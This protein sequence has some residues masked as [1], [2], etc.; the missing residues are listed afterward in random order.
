MTMLNRNPHGDRAHVVQPLADVESDD[1]QQRGRAQCEQ[2]ENNVERGIARKMF[3]IRLPHEEHVAGGEVEHGR[4]VGQV[5]GPISPRRHEA[6][7]I[8]EGA[9]APDIKPAFIR[10]ARR[11]FQH[12]KRQRRVET[13]PGADPDDDR[14]RPGGRGGCD[15][16]Q[17]DA[18]D[19]IKQNQVAE[20]HHL[21]GPIGIFR[22]RDGNPRRRLRQLTHCG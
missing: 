15:P 21:L 20:A 18:G 5:A 13:Q 8:S 22:L 6:G 1:I 10:I 17:A 9:L 2:R 19:H 7:E 14:T 12:R 11:K 16:A 4:E 3:P